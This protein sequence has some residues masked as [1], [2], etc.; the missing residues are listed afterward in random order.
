MTLLNIST[1]N[2]VNS[3]SFPM[4]ANGFSIN[5]M[6]EVRPEQPENVHEPIELTLLGMII[7]VRLLQPSKA[8]PP[9][10]VTGLGMVIEVRLRH[11]RNA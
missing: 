6:M 1:S 8:P 3:D 9:I 2:I 4:T 11:P 7:E 5:E 10:L